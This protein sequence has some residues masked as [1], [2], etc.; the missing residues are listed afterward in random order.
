MRND[1]NVGV[2]ASIFETG[3]KLRWEWEGRNLKEQ[4]FR[5]EGV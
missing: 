4:G 5:E 1:R 3:V 2:L